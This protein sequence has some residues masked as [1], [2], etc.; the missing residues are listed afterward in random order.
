MRE[1]RALLKKEPKKALHFRELKHEQR[2][3]Y[4]RAIGDAN[5]HSVG[6]DSQ[7]VNQGTGA[8]QSESFASPTPVA[9]F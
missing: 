9:C 8:F 2:V 3:P 1:V 7:A 6:V 5:L 4:V